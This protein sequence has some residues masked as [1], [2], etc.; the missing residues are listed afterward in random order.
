MGLREQVRA[1]ITY[2]TVYSGTLQCGHY[3]DHTVCIMLYL[4]TFRRRSI[5]WALF[6]VNFRPLQEIE[7]IMVGG[8]IFDT[9]PFFGRLQYIAIHWPA[10]P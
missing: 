1:G 9:G 5:G 6:G 3:W 2:I 7:P 4:K 10:I 8:Q